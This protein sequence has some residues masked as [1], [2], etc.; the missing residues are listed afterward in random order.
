MEIIL[1]IFNAL[2]LLGVVYFIVD[3]N[4]KLYET[5]E[6]TQAEYFK[7]LEKFSQK[8]DAIQ[9]KS[10]KEFLKVFAQ[11][12]KRDIPVEVPKV[13]EA[14]QVENS[15]ENASEPEEINLTDTP[16]I[17]IVDGVKIKFEDEEE[18]VQMNINPI[19][20]YQENKS[21]NPIEK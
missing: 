20:N 10:N 13:L 9:V 8:S 16:R 2:F 1:I 12:F 5:F 18:V 7:A 11:V 21:E 3:G 4:K 17:P 14:D 19:E 15:I 6:K